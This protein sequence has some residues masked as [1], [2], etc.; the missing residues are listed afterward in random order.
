[1]RSPGGTGKSILEHFFVFPPQKCK[2]SE[3]LL[4][5]ILAAPILNPEYCKVRLLLLWSGSLALSTPTLTNKLHSYASSFDIYIST[6]V[7]R[8]HPPDPLAG[9]A[10]WSGSI[11]TDTST[12]MCARTVPENSPTSASAW[13]SLNS[14]VRVQSVPLN[15]RFPKP[16]LEPAPVHVQNHIPGSLL[17]RPSPC[18][19]W[20]R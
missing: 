5:V 16:Y 3:S 4:F 14:T 20:A 11:R 18:Q 9:S 7:P 19:Q 1:M 8:E 15:F 17:R 12:P 6:R 10:N 13:T 2:P